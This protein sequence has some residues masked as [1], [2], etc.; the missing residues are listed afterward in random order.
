MD[1]FWVWRDIM[2]TCSCIVVTFTARTLCN[3]L[4]RL[5]RFGLQS[6]RNRSLNHNLTAAAYIWTMVAVCLGHNSDQ[7]K[8][9]SAFELC[10]HHLVVHSRCYMN[11]ASA[12]AGLGLS[13][14]L[15]CLRATYS[16][17]LKVSYW[18]R[19]KRETGML[20]TDTS[21]RGVSVGSMPA[22]PHSRTDWLV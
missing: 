19:A 21:C 17:V 3:G 4:N 15:L 11:S 5:L 20:L 22:Q 6:D 9:T 13:I 7:I 2:C 14:Y 12:G 10:E 18:G 8:G 1:C 16:S